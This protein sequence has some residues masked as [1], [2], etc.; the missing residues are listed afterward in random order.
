M[1][2]EFIV[3]AFT[4]SNPPIPE[5]SQ[6]INMEAAD[7]TLIFGH[8]TFNR[9]LQLLKKLDLRLRQADEPEEES[10]GL[11]TAEN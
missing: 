5:L 6:I 11:L 7:V 1:S 4:M 2:T 10:S 3:V 8:V 9:S